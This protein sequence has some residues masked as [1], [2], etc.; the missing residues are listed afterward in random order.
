MHRIQQ[1]VMSAPVEQGLHVVKAPL[2]TRR[3][4]AVVIEHRLVCLAR[5]LHAAEG[6]RVPDEGCNQHALMRVP[7]EGR[8]R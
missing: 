7:D 8:N 2:F 1:D 4:G 6:R 3:E 5:H